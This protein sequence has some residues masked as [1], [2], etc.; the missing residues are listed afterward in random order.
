MA[1]AR[2]LGIL[3]LSTCVCSDTY[4]QPVLIFM[5]ST[6]ECNQIQ[7]VIGALLTAQMLV[8]D[9]QVLSGTADLAPPTIPTQNLFSEL[10][11]GFGIELQARSLWLNPPHDAFSV[12]SCRKA[13][14]W[15]PGRNEEA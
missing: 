11:V 10:F 8:V 4:A 12:T 1:K 5:T 3:N 7:F 2:W 15:S 14:C 6:A 9:L 13:C